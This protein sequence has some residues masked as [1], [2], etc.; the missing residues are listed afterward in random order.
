M[1]VCVCGLLFILIGMVCYWLDDEKSLLNFKLRALDLLEV[2]I[3]RE[4]TNPRI[5]VSEQ[6]VCVCK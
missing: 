2:F 5:L 3:R 4:S 6:V 1:C